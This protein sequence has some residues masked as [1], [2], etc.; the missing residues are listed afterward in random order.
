[1]QNMQCKM[2]NRRGGSPV[3]ILSFAFPV[4]HFAFSVIPSRFRVLAAAF[5][6]QQIVAFAVSIGSRLT[7]SF[8]ESRAPGR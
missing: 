6:P 8:F 4:A 3:S 1:M 7:F 5:S 2:Q